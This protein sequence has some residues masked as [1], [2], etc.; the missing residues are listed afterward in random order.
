MRFE[1]SEGTAIDRF[2]DIGLATDMNII[3]FNILWIGLA[4][5]IV[6]RIWRI[7][8]FG[9]GKS[10]LLAYTFYLENKYPAGKWEI[11]AGITMTALLSFASIGLMYVFLT[12]SLIIPRVQEK[13]L[14]IVV[15][16][17]LFISVSL[18]R[19]RQRKLPYPRPLL[20]VGDYL[21]LVFI[22]VSVSYSNVM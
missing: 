13:Y 20:I 12:G 19:W 22:V 9:Y 2:Q 11:A 6:N 4:A 7:M 18:F 3:V 10:G 8:K 5:L 17:L 1:L 16:D 15:G 14:V 21:L